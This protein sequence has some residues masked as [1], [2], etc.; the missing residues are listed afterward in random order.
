MLIFA[1]INSIAFPLCRER[2]NLAVTLVNQDGELMG[3][4]CFLDYPNMAEI[5]AGQWE[6][7]LKSS[8][9]KASG[10]NSVNTLFLHFFVARY[11]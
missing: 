6:P 4:A 8:Y 3:Q 7:W 10:S 11:L 2:A 9:S 1:L 5:D